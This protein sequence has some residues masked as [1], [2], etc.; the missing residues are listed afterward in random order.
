MVVEF[1][2]LL[3]QPPFIPPYQGGKSLASNTTPL[4][5]PYQG[6]KSLTAR[7]ENAIEFTVYSPLSEGK[8]TLYP[9][10]SWGNDFL[11]IPT[12]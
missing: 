7:S 8:V 3:I 4:Y 12:P 11:L 5:P 10:A 2:T 1:P 6:G 9:P